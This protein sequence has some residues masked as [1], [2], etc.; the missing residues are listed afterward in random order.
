MPDRLCR[1][2][3]RDRDC[4]EEGSRCEPYEYF[5]LHSSMLPPGLSLT[6]EGVISG[7]PMTGFWRFWLSDR[8]PTAE[9]GGPSGCEFEDKS[10][11]EFS[12]SV[13]PGLA[14]ST[15]PVKQAT[16]GQ[17]YADTHGEAGHEPEPFT[18]SDV[19]ATWSL[20]SGALSPGLAMSP[21]GV[22]SGTPTAEGSWGSSGGS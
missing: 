10:E 18:G 19:R 14:S 1:R 9:Q 21:S 4:V 5:E 22:L 17:P 2:G 20:P 7:V 11:R 16:I 15:S 8:D 3:I 6:R 12:I 13:E